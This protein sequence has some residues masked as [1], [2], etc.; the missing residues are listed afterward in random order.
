[1]EGVASTLDYSALQTMFVIK[2]RKR[3]MFKYRQSVSRKISALPSKSSVHLMGMDGGKISGCQHFSNSVAL[4]PGERV[5]Y[6]AEWLPPQVLLNLRT[7]LIFL[8]LWSTND[9]VYILSWPQVS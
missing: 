7:Y 1:M 4:T 5:E 9:G 3:M 6:L 8:D 2:K